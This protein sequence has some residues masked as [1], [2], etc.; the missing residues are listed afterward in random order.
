MK[1]HTIGTS[2][3]A[4]ALMMTAVGCQSSRVFYEPNLRSDLAPQADREV[5][6]AADFG[7]MA[8]DQQPVSQP[9]P[10]PN[11]DKQLQS[12]NTATPAQ[13]A[14]EQ[15]SKSEKSEKSDKG[16]KKYTAP[17]VQMQQ[18]TLLALGIA[19]LGTTGQDGYAAEASQSATTGGIVG[20]P[21]LTAPPQSR[22]SS[23]VVGRPGLQSGRAL[24]LGPANQTSNIYIATRNPLTGANGACD[25]L[26]RN[27][28]FNGNRAACENHFRR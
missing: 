23:A 14:T 21:E 24:S 15:P 22:F 12:S 8:A 10:K 9:A 5:L 25:Q 1:R 16:E 20:R 28:F 11:Q 18:I 19:S 2:I 27:N 17:S 3:L 4:I 7:P 6:L 13:N 26:T